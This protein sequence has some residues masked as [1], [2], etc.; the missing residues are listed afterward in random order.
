LRCADLAIPC[1]PL[2]DPEA[3]KRLM[4]G[5]E[6]K[7]QHLTIPGTNLADN[8]VAPALEAGKTAEFRHAPVFD[9][10]RRD[11]RRD[12]FGGGTGLRQQDHAEAGQDGRQQDANEQPALP[13]MGEPIG[14]GHRPGKREPG[15]FDLR[16]GHENNLDP[17]SVSDPMM[18]VWHAR[19]EPG[20]SPRFISH[21]P[22]AGGPNCDLC[23]KRGLETAKSASHLKDV[24]AKDGGAIPG[25]ALVADLI[26]HVA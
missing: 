22:K 7:A 15:L 4:S 1:F 18:M 12:H 23:A 19:P 8:A 3:E 24:P 9:K 25:P 10:S 17:G 5:I 16:A 6:H 2:K 20:A 26:L 11:R 13:A 14:A 21:S